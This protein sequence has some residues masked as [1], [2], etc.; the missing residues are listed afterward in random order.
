MDIPQNPMMDQPPQM[1]EQQVDPQE[2]IQQLTQAEQQELVL[3]AAENYNLAQDLDDG[4]LREVAQ[5]I[6]SGF[7]DDE[8][9]RAEWLDQHTFWLSLY[10]QQDYAENSDSERDWGA[11]ESVPILSEACDS[12]QGRT[13]KR[14]FPQDNFVSARPMRKTKENRKELEERAQ[15]IG[16]HMSYQLGFVDQT[17]KED[18]DS[19]FLGVAVHGSFF[20]KTYYSDK[21]G[22]AKVDNVRPTDLVVNYN[23]GPVRIEDLRRKTHIIYTT[24][25]ETQ[26]LVNKGFFIEAATPAQQQG[27]NAYNIKVDETQG[28]SAPSS[29]KIKRDAPAVLYEQHFY[30]DLDGNEEYR[31]YIG[32]ICAASR[33]LLRLT[34]G[35]EAD[36]QGNPLK[37]YEQI[38]YFTH[39]KYKN[40]PDGFYGL[41]LGHSIGDLNS[42]VNIMLRQTMDAATL[43]NDGNMSGF[44]SERLGLEGDEISMV[45]G[46]FRKIPDT[47]GD[48][49]NSLM[50]MKFPGPNAALLQIME[51]MDARAQRLGSVTEATT[52]TPDKVIQP[53]TY[54]AQLEQAL[55]PFSSSQ[56]RLAGAF[57]LE[58]QKIFRINQRYL[59]LVDYYIVNDEPETI[60]RQDYADD[61][62]I[63]PAFDPK[64]ATQAQKVSRA[65]AELQAT[66]QNPVN[67]GR[68]QVIDTAFKRYLEALDVD[69]ID[70]LIPPQPQVENFDD[71]LVENMFFL[72]PKESRPLFDVFPDQNHMQHLAQL[73]MFVAQYGQQLQP[74]QQQDILKHQQKHMGYF[75]GQQNGIIPPP[76]PG[77]EPTPPL[78]AR[79]N[80]PM[81][82]GGIGQA[83]S[84]MASGPATQIPGGSMPQGGPA[85]GA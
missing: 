68:P 5:E 17:F 85:T 63:A 83:L 35:Y 31:P 48:M 23:M 71:Q 44:I 1:G 19:L 18:K 7:A 10:M 81:D 27:K 70:E 26:D 16:D 36:P 62:L 20:T 6:Y 52:G 25:G 50:Q 67:Q 72:M 80:N 37:D 40:N 64:S 33:R 3:H 61:M 69:N 43:A 42:A 22:R 47:V 14:F 45:L 57:G 76:P 9:S 41:G 55:E 24:V 73:E 77:S 78:A 13:Y 84:P 66:L 12:Y 28:L 30:L 46:K 54:M 53:T 38:Q 79:S 15:R 49:Q 82:N 65:Q 75:Y 60:T 59:P 39:Y 34:I 8:E 2:M 32:T 29:T 11:T 21:L 51:S 58:L 4:M 74:D 56:I